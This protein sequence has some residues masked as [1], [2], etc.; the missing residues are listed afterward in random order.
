LSFPAP[1]PAAEPGRA[2][3]ES[4]RVSVSSPGTRP[5]HAEWTLE[6]IVRHG[7]EESAAAGHDPVDPVVLDLTGHDPESAARQIERAA[8]DEVPLCVIV[9]DREH[10]VGH[11]QAA[12]AV[13]FERVSLAEVPLDASREFIL[14]TR[15]VLFAFGPEAA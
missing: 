11:A 13:G 10:R 8:D 1:P 7:V 15:S 6:A 2:G 5:S 4:A 9:S 14:G 3:L 12:R